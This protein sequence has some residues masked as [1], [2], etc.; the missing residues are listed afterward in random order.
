MTRISHADH[1]SRLS[2]LQN[3]HRRA[4]S[5]RRL[6]HRQRITR[7]QRYY[8]AL[9]AHVRITHG[10]GPIPVMIRLA[11]LE[12]LHASLPHEGI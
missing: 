8:D 12:H 5:N 1:H 9:R 7:Q 10:H 11:Q 6:N 2:S 3:E 4:I